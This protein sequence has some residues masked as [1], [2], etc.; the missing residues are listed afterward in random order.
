MEAGSGNVYFGSQL[1]IVNGTATFGGNLSAPTGTLGSLTISST[2]NI[3]GGQTA[4]N[5][6]TG[7]WLGNSGGTWAFSLG[8]SAGANMRWDG[9]SL[10][11]NAPVITGASFDSFTASASGASTS[12][13]SNGAVSG[14]YGSTCTPSGGK[15]PYTYTWSCEA[16]LPYNTGYAVI[17]SG[18][19]SASVSIRSMGTNQYNE[20]TLTCTVTDANGRSAVASKFCRINHGTP[21]TL[22]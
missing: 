4:Y 6:G 9:S 22:P 17:E 16:Y 11:V 15:S 10:L 18:A 20:I 7:F 21:G 12:N 19:S 1:Q 8:N 13:V 14:A 3:K 2:G 5:T